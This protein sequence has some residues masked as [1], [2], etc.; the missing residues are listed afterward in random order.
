MVRLCVIVHCPSSLNC[1]L[2]ITKFHFNPLF[3]VWPGQSSIMTNNKWLRGD[4]YVNIRDTIMFVCYC[5]SSNCHLP[6]NQVLFQSP[7]YFPM[8][9]EKNKMVMG[10]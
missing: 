1:H 7:L 6:I 2:P 5:P 3:K 8:Y 10:R 9:Y 4:N